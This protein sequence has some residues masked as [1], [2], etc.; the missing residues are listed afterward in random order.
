MARVA[1]ERAGRRP[2]RVFYGWLVVL[3]GM[4]LQALQGALFN[5][6]YG[7]YIVVL[8]RDFGW[9]KVVFS[10]GFSVQQALQGVIGPLQGWFIDRFG[11]R[12]QIRL[13]VIVLGGGLMLFSRF[14]SPV[15]FFVAMA[16][17]A[18][19]QSMCGFL[20]LAATTV[21]WFVRKRSLASALVSF[22]MGV[23][24]FLAPIV[25]WSLTRYGWRET[26]FAS[27]LLAIAIGLPLAHLMRHSPEPYGYLPDGDHPGRERPRAAASAT[28]QRPALARDASDDFGVGEAVRTAAFWLIAL[29]HSSA[30][31]VVSAVNVHLISHLKQQLGYSVTQGAAILTLV[32]TMSMIGQVSGGY[33]GDRFN[34]RVLATV[35]M[36]MHAIGLLL[37]AYATS[38]A[39]VIAFAVLHGLAWGVRGPQMQAIRAD[40]FG[41]SNFGKI[42]GVSQ[43]VIMLGTMG[44]PLLAGIMADRFGNYQVG[45]TILAALSALGALFWVLLRKPG[46]RG[47]RE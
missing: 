34:K 19:G 36:F 17:I 31:L 10:A 27:G 2:P 23:G 33:L 21:N 7:A 26:A 13:G 44:G 28:A 39:M 43:P 4:G 5:S 6:A 35:C 8:Q 45:F 32:T 38:L 18:L 41:R 29:G 37:V 14:D 30:L 1:T 40:Y 24:G 22:G 20:P 15:S 12:T 46:R 3:G 11:A 16:V 25:A 47:S 42:Y 9:S